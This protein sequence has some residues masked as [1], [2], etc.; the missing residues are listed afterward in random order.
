MQQADGWHPPCRPVLG[1]NIQ[2]PCIWIQ[3]RLPD[4]PYG[5]DALAPIISAEIMELHH[6]KHHQVRRPAAAARPWQGTA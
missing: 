4:L 3:A 2:L 5:Y 1:A 6:K